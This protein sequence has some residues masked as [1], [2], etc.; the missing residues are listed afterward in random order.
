MG[1]IK[2]YIIYLNN[3][4]FAIATVYLLGRR[5]IGISLKAYKNRTNSLTTMGISIIALGIVLEVLFKDKTF[6]FG[7]DIHIMDNITGIIT[8]LSTQVLL[9]LRQFDSISYI[10]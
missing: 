4:G 5:S 2:P 1:I 7:P 10:Q 8:A 9:G 6:R 3:I